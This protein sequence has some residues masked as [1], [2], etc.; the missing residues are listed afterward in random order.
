MLHTKIEEKRAR[1]RTRWIDQIRRDL[2]MRG[3]TWEE[4]Q[5]EQKVVVQSRLFLCNSRPI[6]LETLESDGDDFLY[7]NNESKEN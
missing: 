4:I 5:K 6:S 1:A 7:R 3:E 2:E